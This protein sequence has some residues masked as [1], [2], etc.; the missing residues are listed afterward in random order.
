MGFSD[1][2]ATDT[3]CRVLF[4]LFDLLLEL[5]SSGA[6]RKNALV[7]KDKV[8]LVELVE[9]RKSKS[10]LVIVKKMFKVKK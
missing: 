4:I 5:S 3:T 8:E 2:L 9:L 10:C 1:F 6:I 7:I